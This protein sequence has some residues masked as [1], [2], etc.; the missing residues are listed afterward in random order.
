MSSNARALI[1][2][3]ARSGSGKTILTIGL[4][5]ALRRRGFR[6]AGVKTGP[7]YIGPSFH[8]A[9]CGRASVNLDGFAMAPETVLGLA[10]CA[11][12]EV[13]LVIGEG[14]MGLFDGAAGAGRSG[15]T[16]DVARLLGWP[17]LLVLDAESAAQTLAAVAHGLATFPR[18]P[19]I[20]GVIVNR[21]ASERHGRMIREGFVRIDLPLLG[22]IPRDGRLALPSR[23]LGLVQATETAGL[24]DLIGA[25]ADLVDVHCDV[26]AIEALAAPVTPSPGFSRVPPPG[27]RIAVARDAAFGFLYPH[28]VEG[29]RRA[30][31]EI[32]FFSPLADEPPPADCD[33]CWL[34]GGYPELHGARIASN[35]RFLDGL[36]LFA[37]TR[38]VHGEC[39][40]YMVLGRAIEDADGVSHA[41]A[42]LLPIETSF[43]RRRLHLG[44]RQLSWRSDMPFAR[45]GSIN[46]GHEYHHATLTSTEGEPLADAVDAEGTAIG[47]MGSRV[48]RVTGSFFHLIA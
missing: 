4:Q 14:A 24:D 33:V 18:A 12:E 26:D 29:W 13:D 23:H 40:G 27:Q 5:R 20:A 45:R 36:R 19:D 42:G 35:G 31:A 44:Y 21:V 25:M 37:E 30:G 34:P 22:L 6:V 39:G 9:A 41:M 2:V 43:A 38:P 1:V 48:G 46:I 32:A 47:P 28:L 15:A 7:D 11:G 8:A 17:V 16:A 10:A 3:A